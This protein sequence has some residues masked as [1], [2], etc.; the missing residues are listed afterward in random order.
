M[1][2][3]IESN[4]DIPL[5]RLSKA[6]REA[7]GKAYRKYKRMQDGAVILRHSPWPIRWAIREKDPRRR[8]AKNLIA[9]RVRRG[10]L[11]TLC[12]MA[13]KISFPRICIAL[14]ISD[15]TQLLEHA[16][17]EAEASDPFLE[18]RL[19]YLEPPEKGVEVIRTILD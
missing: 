14:G 8:A 5:P 11:K 10:I 13:V 12:Y 18:F 17:R 15:P 1:G 6:L 9:L 19:D 16:R 7:V 2:I 4:I 3:T